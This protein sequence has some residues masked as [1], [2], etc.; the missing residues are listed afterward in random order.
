MRREAHGALDTTQEKAKEWSFPR[1]VWQTVSVRAKQ[2]P[3][4]YDLLVLKLTWS[5]RWAP[6]KRRVVSVA[7]KL[8][9]FMESQKVEYL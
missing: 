2:I 9:Q 4:R 7:G 6:K 5:A 8:C 3:G 1:R